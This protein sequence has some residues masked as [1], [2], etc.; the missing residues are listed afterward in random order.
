MSTT[1]SNSTSIAEHHLHL[2]T[3]VDEVFAEL[4][5]RVDSG[6][7]ELDAGEY[8][9]ESQRLVAKISQQL[10]AIEQQR[11]RLVNLLQGL[12]VASE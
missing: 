10:Q 9:A 3:A 12:E 6:R 4:A 5:I 11:D 1:T 8:V 2:T 7:S